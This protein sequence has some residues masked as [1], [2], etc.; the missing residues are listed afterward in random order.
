MT[1]IEPGVLDANVLAYA[2]NTSAPQHSASR[3]LLDSARDHRVTL[4]VTSQILCEFYSIITNPRRVAAPKSSADAQQIVS[5]ILALP[6]LWVLPMPISAVSG[7][8]QLLQRYPVTGADIFDLQIVAT[9][10]A[11]GINCIYTFNGD[12]FRIFP[13]ISVVP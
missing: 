12:D 2:I 1:R 7:W 9:M 3:T 5:D 6:G 13:E 10:L 4:Y 8:L 11:N